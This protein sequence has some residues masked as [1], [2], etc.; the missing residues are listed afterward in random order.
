MT[1]FSDVFILF[2]WSVLRKECDDDM[3]EYNEVI[4]TPD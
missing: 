1:Y 2:D 3:P 4:G